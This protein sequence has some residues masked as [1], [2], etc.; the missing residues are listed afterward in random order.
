MIKQTEDNSNNP[1]HRIP[2]S[3]HECLVSEGNKFVTYYG[4]SYD[5][6]FRKYYQCT[7]EV[8][9]QFDQRIRSL[10]SVARSRRS[11]HRILKRE[12]MSISV[13]M[14]QLKWKIRYIGYCAA[15]MLKNK[16]SFNFVTHKF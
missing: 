11:G 16:S 15:V 1:Q 8:D 7:E 9:R 14:L 13:Y 12:G 2:S 5:L 10:E 4:E 3:F 6:Y